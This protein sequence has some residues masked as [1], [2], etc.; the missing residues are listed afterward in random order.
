MNPNR[1]LPEY[2]PLFVR[3]NKRFFEL[4]DMTLAPMVLD[5]DEPSAAV[6]DAFAQF[7]PDGLATI[8]SDSTGGK[9]PSDHVWKGMVVTSLV[10]NTCGSQSP[11]EL[12]RVMKDAIAARVVKAQPTFAFFRIVWVPPGNVA[13]AVET[14]K[15]G[16]PEWNVEIVDPYTYFALLK[17]HIEPAVE[18]GHNLPSIRNRPFTN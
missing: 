2:L 12:A 3:H 16:Y 10:N 18:G 14:L 1:I 7:A 5:W 8:V 9:L 15:A 11:Q 13:K 6:K 17:R 4:A